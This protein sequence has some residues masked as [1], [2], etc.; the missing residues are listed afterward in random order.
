MSGPAAARTREPGVSGPAVTRPPGAWER[1]ADRIAAAL[2]RPLLA[3]G[4]TLLP[5]LALVSYRP[6]ADPDL[7]AR[8]AVGRLVELNGGVVDTDPFS[9]TA[10]L[11][12][13]VD[14]EWLSGVVFYRVASVAGDMGLLAFDLLMMAL[15]VAIVA[16]AQREIR[17]G[18][19]WSPPWLLLAMVPTFGVWSSVVRS[20]VFTFLCFAVMLLALVRWREGRT[21]WL[22]ALLPLFVLWANAH[23]GFVAGLGLLGAAAVGVSVASPRRASAL[24]ICLALSALATLVNPYGLAYWGYLLGAVTMERPGIAEWTPVP[25]ASLRGMLPL[26]YL[27]VFAGG[28]WLA[29]RRPPAEAFAMVGVAFAATLGSR[30]IVSFLMVVLAVYGGGP[31]R[32]L[33]SEVRRAAPAWWI[34]GRRVLAPAALAALLLVGWRS[35]RSLAWAATH[36]LDYSLFPTGAVEWLRAEGRGGRLLVHFNHGSFAL[37]RLYPE[38]RVSV[39]GRYEETYP[40]ATVDTVY[41][42]LL[43]EHPDHTQSLRAVAPDYILVEGPARAAAFGTA[44]RKVYE[45][46]RFVVLAHDTLTH[47][48][49]PRP[50]R[51][52]WTPGF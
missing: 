24:W 37:W 14:H 48:G 27:A 43:P 32:A 11:A 33:A 39:D 21:R 23:G 6:G 2:R 9:Y 47:D 5:L 44:W 40:Q 18:R 10:G 17:G 46:A 20:R 25:L 7:F 49:P 12:R 29:R 52:M 28:S 1:G 19:E 3:I 50:P 34:A 31:A 16:T 45:D 26:L 38:Y 51:P 22:W 8:T 41:R 30:R 36:G 35:G 15:T 13:W 4:M 42:A